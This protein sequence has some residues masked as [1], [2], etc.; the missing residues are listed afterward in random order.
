MNKKKKIGLALGSGGVRGLAHIGVLKA[1]EKHN[2]EIDFIAGS[3]IGSMV[4]AYYAATTDLAELEQ[5]VL[6]NDWRTSLSL[7][8]PSWSGGLVKGDKVEK[9]INSWFGDINFDNL[10]IPLAIVAT[11]LKSGR[12]IVFKKGELSKI[13]RGSISVPAFF[14]PLKYKNYILAD[15]GLSNPLPDNVVREMGSDIVIAVNLDTVYL[16]KDFNNP[17]T[18]VVNVSLRAIN[19]MRHHLS[20]YSV[21]HADVLISPQ[22]KEKGLIGWNRFFNQKEA[23]KIIKIGEKETEKHIPEI[24][25]KISL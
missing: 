5:I 11:D 8:D 16:S 19:V 23:K 25:E 18:S 15:A 13:I 22:V 21:N 9:M 4:S 3:S 7:L 14:K 20:L 17:N 1:L 24:M 2:I 10:K 12:E 6:Q